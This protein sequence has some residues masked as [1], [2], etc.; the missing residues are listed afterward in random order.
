MFRSNNPAL[1]N[2]AF[3]PAQTWD[4]VHAGRPIAQ[5]R[6]DVMTMSGTVWKSFALLM[7]CTAVGIGG[8]IAIKENQALFAPMLFGGMIVGFILAMIILF[9]PR[10]APFLAPL[11]AVAEG[12]FVAGASIGWTAYAAAGAKGS[13]VASLGTDL[14]L[15]A[16]LLTFGIAACMLIAYGTRLIRPTQ[17]MIGGI[18]AATGGVIV[19]SLVMFLLSWFMPGTVMGFWESPLGLAVAGVIVVLAALNLVVD[20][21][22]IEN[23]V[24]NQAPKHMEWFGGFALL[25]TLVWLYVSLLRLLALIRRN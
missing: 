12:A 14:V 15:Q 2:D 23:G 11:Y 1:R 22:F 24:N 17:R 13:T 21:A 4:S 10:T 25:V 19:F 18:V 7:I 8:W 6:P 16:G 5:A 3:A 20:F 9:K